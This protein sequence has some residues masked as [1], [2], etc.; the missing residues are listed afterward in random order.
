MSDTMGV[1]QT[2]RAVLA[3][4]AGAAAAAA[5]SAVAPGAVRA[6]VDG[7]VVL[8]ANNNAATTTKI[9]MSGTQIG[10]QVDHV[11]GHAA[12]FLSTDGVGVRASSS[13]ERGL[14]A[15]SESDYGAE[16]TSVSARAVYGRSNGDHAI[17]GKTTVAGRFGVIGESSAAAGIGYLGGNVGVLGEHG[18]AGNA[19]VGSSANGIGVVGESLAESGATRGVEGIAFSPDGYGVLGNSNADSGGAGV[20]GG[21]AA[22]SGET[23]GVIGQ[24]QSPE[25]F[26]VLADTQS[27]DAAARALVA[28]A[29]SGSGIVGWSG[30]G[31]H[32]AGRASTGVFGYAATDGSSVGIRGESP[33]GT[34]VQAVTSTGIALR[35]AGK[36]RLSR[37]GK[38]SVKSGSRSVD[39]TVPG[40]IA[41]NTVVI[42]TIQTHRTGIGV[43]GVKLN[44]PSAGKARIYLTKAV[45]SA[46]PVG[47]MAVET[48]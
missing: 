21:T 41:S 17:W 5:A 31:S 15:T 12:T 11:S 32:P 39:V 45:S 16:I 38:A 36:A 40:G 20:Y 8:G 7:D 24:V 30:V 34:G 35:V 37:S 14:F 43:A 27:Q 33:A 47:W 18:G 25:G 10:F 2:R 3:G 13:T 29:P 19:V 42:A 48:G 23:A 22:T 44:S 1:T 6:G 26:G 9:T 28:H 4:A 46:T